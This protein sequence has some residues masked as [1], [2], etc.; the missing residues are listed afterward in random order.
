MNSSISEIDAKVVCYHCGNDCKDE[1]ILEDDKHFCCSGCFT[2]Y[3]ILK[4]NNLCGYYD[5]NANAGVSLR[6]KNFKVRRV[7][8]TERMVL[9]ISD[10][11]AIIAS[12]AT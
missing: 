7:K 10:D 9:M 8:K 11:A 5:L 1:D 6:A 3:D 2:V 4:D 12:K